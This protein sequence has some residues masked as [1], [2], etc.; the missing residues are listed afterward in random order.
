[1]V[2]I[3]R[4]PLQAPMSIDTAPVDANRAVL[5]I[6]RDFEGIANNAAGDIPRDFRAV[7]SLDAFRRGDYVC[8]RPVQF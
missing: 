3:E 4:G 5:P 8:G 1:M 7:R 6:G 2:P